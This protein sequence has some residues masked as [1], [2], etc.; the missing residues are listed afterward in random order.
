MRIYTTQYSSNGINTHCKESTGG[1]VSNGAD[2][3]QSFTLYSSLE[4]CAKEL[5]AFMQ[6]CQRDLTECLLLCVVPGYMRDCSRIFPYY[7]SRRRKFIFRV[8]LSEFV[9]YSLIDVQKSASAS[10]F[11]I[12]L[13]NIFPHIIILWA[14]Y[15]TVP[16]HFER[17]CF[18]HFLIFA[19][20]Q[21]DSTT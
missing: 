8:C 18:S 2:N 10:D 12:L 6:L 5:V 15:T 19:T 20:F 16:K 14:R 3:R 9:I 21:S 13:H 7:L 17:S 11:M 4:Q 1:T